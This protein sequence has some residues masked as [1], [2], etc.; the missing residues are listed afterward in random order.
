MAFV[1]R[2]VIPL[3]SSCIARVTVSQD[4]LWQALW[5]ECNQLWSNNQFD[6]R[7]HGVRDAQHLTLPNPNNPSERIGGPLAT[8]W[9]R[10][11]NHQASQD[12]LRTGRP[13]GR[14]RGGRI[15]AR[16]DIADD[17]APF[18][19]RRGINCVAIQ[20]LEF[21]QACD[22]SRPRA[23]DNHQTARRGSFAQTGRSRRSVFATRRTQMSTAGV[24]K[25]MNRG[26]CGC[27]RMM[28]CG[29]R[30]RDSVV[31]MRWSD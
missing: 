17:Y 1:A 8:V 10:E 13:S 12:G 21:A 19:F 29:F 23:S 27:P 14:N 15:I 9:P 3:Y 31:V 4:E 2:D 16:V 24:R 5:N 20:N 11:G 26:R 22:N 30:V 25:I 7:R 18:K 28:V 6:T